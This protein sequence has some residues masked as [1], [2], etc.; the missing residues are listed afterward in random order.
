[1]KAR[2]VIVCWILTKA[3]LTTALA[4]TE[5]NSIYV[6]LAQ[7]RASNEVQTVIRVLPTIE[8]LWPE[9]PETYFRSAGE[10]AQALAGAKRNLAAKNALLNL[11]TNVVQKPLPREEERAL[12]CVRLKQ[13]MILSLLPVEYIRGD[14]ARWG[15]VATFLG[16]VRARIIPNYENQ[17]GAVSVAA[18]TPEQ[19]LRLQAV[20]TE[21]E[22]G[23]AADR[24]QAE[25]R[26]RDREIA[27]PLLYYI[28]GKLLTDTQ[29]VNA[30]CTAAHLTPQ[31]E[32]QLKGQIGG[33][34]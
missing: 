16:Q 34:L 14:K 15:D 32:K 28:P 21:T 26:S 3:L 22:R 19:K 25:L 33:G 13:D 23:N 7:A 1:M 30:V 31:E 5:T 20:L 17:G 9:Q 2:L 6:M 24:R 10:A 12:A 4:D 11:W 8:T 27:L 18:H 29:F